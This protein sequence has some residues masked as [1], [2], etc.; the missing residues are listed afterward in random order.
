MLNSF[1]TAYLQTW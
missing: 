1:K